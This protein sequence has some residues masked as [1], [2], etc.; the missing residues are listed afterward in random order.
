M[1]QKEAIMDL[2]GKIKRV[3][4]RK[5]KGKRKENKDRRKEKI[6]RNG[7][8]IKGLILVRK[9]FGSGVMNQKKLSRK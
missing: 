2:N 7:E 1:G 5:E 8:R 9:H 3:K 4:E 6:I